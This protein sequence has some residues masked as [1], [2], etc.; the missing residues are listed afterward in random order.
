MSLYDEDFKMNERPKWSEVY[1]KFADILKS[2]STCKRAAVGCVVTSWDHN[3]VLAIGYNGNYSGGP[4]T[5]D[6]DE[7]GACGCLHGEENAIIKLD[8]NDHSMKRLYTTTS[9]CLMC[10]KR[11]I[12]AGIKQ[13]VYSSLYRK[14]DGID[15]LRKNS[16]EIVYLD[17]IFKS[18]DPVHLDGWLNPDGSFIR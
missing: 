10:S 5:C 9:P 1:L 11:I 12:N 2:R 18:S 16:I 3:R 17:D 7:P 15:L 6:S 14:N 8:Y 13:V 4:N